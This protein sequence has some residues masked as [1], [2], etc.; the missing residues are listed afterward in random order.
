MKLSIGFKNRSILVNSF[1][2][3]PSVLKRFNPLESGQQL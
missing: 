1:E 2:M 3:G